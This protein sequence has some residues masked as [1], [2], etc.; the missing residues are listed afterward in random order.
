M[1]LPFSDTRE[2]IN[3]FLL[4]N[5]INLGSNKLRKDF[6]HSSSLL[7]EKITELQNKNKGN[8]EDSRS[9]DENFFKV[10]NSE[11]KLIEKSPKGRFLKEILISMRKNSEEEHTKLF[12]KVLI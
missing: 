6:K 5:N 12:I 8:I 9:S 3:S 11:S 4:K 1:D 10:R 2:E 7:F